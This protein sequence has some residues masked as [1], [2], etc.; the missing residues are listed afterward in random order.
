VE[1]K[2]DLDYNKPASSQLP[3][4]VE[5]SSHVISNDDDDDVFGSTEDSDLKKHALL[6]SCCGISTKEKLHDKELRSLEDVLEESGWQVKCQTKCKVSNLIQTV[7]SFLVDSRESERI[8][9]FVY[10]VGPTVHINGENYLLPADLKSPSSR[11]D[12]MHS[13]LNINWLVSQLSKSYMQVVVVDGALENALAD[14][15]LNGVLRGLAP[16]CPPTNAIIAFPCHPGTLRTEQERLDYI[17]S[18]VKN[19]QQE[20]LMLDALFDKVREDFLK[21]QPSACGLP[22]E[23]SLTSSLLPL[24]VNSAEDNE[25]TQVPSLQ[26]VTCHA[27]IVSNSVYD[28]IGIKAQQ[29]I[30]DRETLRMALLKT[31]WKCE[32]ICDKSAKDIKDDLRKILNRLA[33]K[34]QTLVMV[35]FMGY[36]KMIMDCNYFFGKDFT[37]GSELL[38]SSVPLQWVVD[39]MCEKIRGPKILI[40]DDL[41]PHTTG[42]AEMTTPLDVMISLP[43]GGDPTRPQYDTSV[44]SNFAHLLET[45]R[46]RQLSL[47]EILKKAAAFDRHRLSSNLLDSK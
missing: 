28:G 41:N 7:H 39:L 44:T 23:F 5:D 24:C 22:V 12:L 8:I 45:R 9:Y 46:A 4:P 43:K 11:A 17:K 31:G 20:S 16:I 38:R 32:E 19:L 13:A 14:V 47:K 27:I 1:D 40:V 37:V 35:H 18:V 3:Y 34:K 33:N 21:N 10:L 29:C 26:N 2:E 42:L 25:G 36:T 6:I 15:Q 30:K